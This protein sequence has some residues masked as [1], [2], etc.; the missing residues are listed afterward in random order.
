MNKYVLVI[1][2]CDNDVI[3]VKRRYLDK[4]SNLD[5]PY[6]IC[7]YNLSNINFNDI[8]GILFVGGGDIDPNLYCEKDLGVSS[9]FYND[10]DLF[11]IELMQICHLKNIPTLAICRGMQVMNVALG[12]TLSQDIDGHMQI[13]PLSKTSHSI[14]IFPNTFLYSIIKKFN[15][16]VNSAHHQTIGK[17]ASTLIASAVC[18][19]VVECLE[20]YSKTFFVGVLWHTEA[21]K[22][23]VIFK[24]FKNSMFL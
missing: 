2:S 19:N 16:D 12:G 4:L 10:R 9:V 20:D 14:N 11:E 17:V 13:E 1:P 21:L 24:A 3:F 18:N 22:D 15:L 8:L 7:S 6:M 5:L 23:D